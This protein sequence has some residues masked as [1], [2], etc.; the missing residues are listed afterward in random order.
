MAS[1]PYSATGKY[2]KRMSNYCSGCKFNPDKAVGDDACPFT[3]LY[4]DFLSRHREAFAGNQR[5]GFQ[6]RNLDKKSDS[7][8]AAIRKQ[9]ATVIERYARVD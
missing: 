8:V 1:K 7:D 6:L 9:A 2:I 5:M 4:W 3:T